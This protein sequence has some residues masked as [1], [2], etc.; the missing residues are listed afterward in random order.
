V[1]RYDGIADWYD[2][3]F[4]HEVHAPEQA[5]AIRLLGRGS[6]RLLDLGCGT[7][8]KTLEFRDSGWAIT[9]VDSSADMLGLARNRGLNVVQANA[10]ALPFDDASFDAVVSLWTHTDIDEFGAAVGEA[11]RVLRPGSPFVYAG[12]HPC[13]VGPHSR[14]I[15]AEGIPELHPGYLDER[16][17]GLEAAGVASEEGLRAKV[18]A[19]HL[20][21][22]NFLRSFLDAGLTLER[23]EE[24]ELASRAYPFAIVLRWRR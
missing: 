22:G 13:F 14:F 20:T 21:L 12:A 17:Y 6:G 18:G 3:D 7:G 4:L 9:G 19:V 2:R 15:R 24:L 5:A 1:T 11:A 8:A 10:A 23:F 16:R